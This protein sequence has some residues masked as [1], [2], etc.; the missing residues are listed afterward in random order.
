MPRNRLERATSIW[1]CEAS[2]NLPVASNECETKTQFPK[3]VN[4]CF[5]GSL[6]GD[7]DRC[8]EM[9]EEIVR[10]DTGDEENYLI[11]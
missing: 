3:E 7:N 11:E 8:L 5:H 1:R 9:R 10:V 6:I 2:G 4:D